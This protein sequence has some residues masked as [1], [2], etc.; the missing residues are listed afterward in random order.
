MLT[1]LDDGQHGEE[2]GVVKQLSPGEY[3]FPPTM[4]AFNLWNQQKW[5]AEQPGNIV[6]EFEGNCHLKQLSA[7]TDQTV[8]TLFMEFDL[9]DLAQ[10]ANNIMV[11]L[12]RFP[13]QGKLA[14]V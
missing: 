10:G 13:G 3:L 8:E 6:V 2:D 1:T 5:K 14:S 7:L 4:G 9:L 12:S 11:A